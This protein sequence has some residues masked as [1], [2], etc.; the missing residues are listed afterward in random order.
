MFERAR[1]RNEDSLEKMPDKERIWTK[2]YMLITVAN[3]FIAINFYAQLTTG[4]YFAIF[5]LGV[6]ETLAG[7]AA[8]L[9][10]VGSLAARLILSKY[11]RQRHYKL[12]LVIDISLMVIFTALHFTVNGFA[13]F[14]VFRFLLGATYGISSNV[15]M[16]I[17]ALIIPEGRKGEGVAWYSMSQ[18]LGMAMGPF[19]AIY[20]MHSFGFDGVFLLLTIVTAIA[21]AIICFVKQPEEAERAKSLPVADSARVTDKPGSEEPGSNKPESDKRRSAERRPDK[22]PAEERGIWQF[23]ERT[24]VRISIFCVIIYMCNSN[25]QSF[26]PVFITES[27]APGLS[28][29][30][31]LASAGAMLAVRPLIGKLFD[32]YGPNMLILFGLII[33]TAGFFLIGQG[34]LS[35]FVPAALL[36]GMGLSSIYGTTLTVVVS[37]SPRHRLNVANATYFLALDL[38]A[39]VGPA[40][41]GGIAEHMGY[42][43]MYFVFAVVVAACI[44]LYFGYVAKGRAR[45]KGR[46]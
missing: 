32:K 7:F 43:M 15:F 18:I 42:S 11:A 6:S 16:T 30:I 41:G 17:I 4:A 21:L 40:I 9:F 34:A 10:V 1:Q 31:F 45:M 24:A 26:A 46:A 39:A 29:A 33:Y 38:G 44:P 5:E 22:L 8:G 28:S 37:D 23:L 12:I 2:E 14:C 35:L 36:I 3:F 19:C 20:I 25:Y 27:G 13:V